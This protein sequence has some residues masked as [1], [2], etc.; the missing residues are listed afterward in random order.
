MKLPNTVVRFFDKAPAPETNTQT[1]TGAFGGVPARVSPSNVSNVFTSL[2]GRSMAGVSSPI[3]ARPPS[4]P[5]LKTALYHSLIPGVG[6]NLGLDTTSFRRG[7][8]AIHPAAVTD[9]EHVS[10]NGVHA[11]VARKVS[12]G[13]GSV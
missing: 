4:A 8:D 13:N 12:R 11:S 5:M 6:R 2:P 7:T 3:A 1:L 9:V 10:A